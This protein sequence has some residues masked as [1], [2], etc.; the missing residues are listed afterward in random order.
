LLYQDTWMLAVLCSSPIAAE[1]LSSLLGP[2]AERKEVRHQLPVR[3]THSLLA[4]SEGITVIVD[5][6]DHQ[7]LDTSGRDEG[8]E[9]AVY[10]SVEEH[11]HLLA[12][13]WSLKRAVQHYRAA[14][15][16]NIAAANHG[17]FVLLRVPLQSESQ[18][19]EAF[20]RLLDVAADVLKVEQASCI[21]NP[22]GE[23][24]GGRERFHEMKHRYRAEGLPPLELLANAR[25]HEIGAGWCMVDTVGLHQ[26]DLPDQEIVFHPD[27]LEVEEA[28]HFAR[29]LA[30]HLI[31]HRPHL[32]SGETAGGPHESIWE[33]MPLGRGALPPHRTAVRWL[34]E[35]REGMPS[36]MAVP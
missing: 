32:V 30:M 12:P 27:R 19:I 10:A 16:A 33:A 17:A 6:Y 8:P 36:G 22:R 18:T 24:L 9:S 15:D 4:R 31:Q 34:P 20:E 21:F 5:L 2:A 35:E 23:T 14:D 13:P 3:P 11:E 29:N 25:F 26:L 1:A 7:W 28:M